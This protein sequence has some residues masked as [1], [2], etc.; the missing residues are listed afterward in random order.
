MFSNWTMKREL[1]RCLRVLGCFRFPQQ[2][3]TDECSFN[4]EGKKILI[5]KKQRKR[6]C[7]NSII[8]KYSEDNLNSGQQM[9]L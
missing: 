4:Q 6:P 5:C 1:W 9:S 2:Q 7:G 3:A 8:T